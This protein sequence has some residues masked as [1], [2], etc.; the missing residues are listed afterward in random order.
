MT[1]DLARVIPIYQSRITE[2]IEQ[3]GKP[4]MLYFDTM[5]TEGTSTKFTDK[6]REGSLRKPVWKELTTDTAPTIVP[7]TREIVA[8]LKYNPRD[9]EIKSVSVDTAEGTVRLKTF[10][11]DVPDLLRA[12]YIIPSSNDTN[13]VYQKYR[14]IKD[15]TPV[16]LQENFFAVSYW[17]LIT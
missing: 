14:M 12:D 11:R 1:L 5:L 3:L 15:P 7:S 2:L 17:E 9:F 6:A 10:L 8:L 13:V 16:G 4:V